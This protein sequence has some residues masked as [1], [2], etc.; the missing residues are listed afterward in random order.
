VIETLKNLPTHVAVSCLSDHYAA[1]P[2][3]RHLSVSGGALGGNFLT[4]INCV[5]CDAC[6]L[7]LRPKPKL[8]PTSV[9]FL[10][11]DGEQRTLTLPLDPVSLLG[12][13]GG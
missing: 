12:S 3:F 9:T 10:N 8:P 7:E 4:R 1:R 11:E 5:T 2:R 6:W 13:V